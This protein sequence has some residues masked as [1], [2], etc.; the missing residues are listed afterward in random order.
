MYLVETERGRRRGEE[1]YYLYGDDPRRRHRE[2]LG[3]KHRP[4]T[5]AIPADVARCPQREARAC[6]PLL[7]RHRGLLLRR[8]RPLH[9]VPRRAAEG[10]AALG[11]PPRR[12]G[13]PAARGAHR[14][15]VSGPSRLPRSRVSTSP[16][17]SPRCSAV[18]STSSRALRWRID[19]VGAFVAPQ[20]LT[21]LLAS[22]LVGR[23]TRAPPEERA[24]PV[25][26]GLQPA[27]HRALH[28]RLRRRPRL[29]AAGAAPQA[30]APRRHV[31]AFPA[32]DALDRAEHRFLVAG[33]PLLTIGILTGTLW[34][35]EIEGGGSWRLRARR[36][37]TRRGRSSAASSSCEPRR[38]A[39]AEGGAT[40]PSSASV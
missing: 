20:A 9:R 38:V 35:H 4:S 13:R 14:P 3:R 10:R 8:V 25:P 37:P 5:G 29:P 11:A 12:A 7:R 30:E 15:L 26:R 24:P 22:R 32:V 18:S 6:R 27:R 31:R 34:A 39:R 17:A 23:S 1:P 2:G 16:S 33:F 19:V 36:S 28:A 21:F 40:G